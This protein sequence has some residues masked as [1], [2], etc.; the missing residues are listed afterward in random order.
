MGKSIFELYP[1]ESWEHIVNTD[2]WRKYVDFFGEEI[3]SLF[4]DNYIVKIRFG[5]FYKEVINGQ[6]HIAL[7]SLKEYKDNISLVLG[8][9]MLFKYCSHKSISEASVSFAIFHCS[10][11]DIVL[12]LL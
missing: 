7:K 9:L 3:N 11:Y 1:K 6:Y 4:G 10:A 8:S 12:S 2:L 5:H